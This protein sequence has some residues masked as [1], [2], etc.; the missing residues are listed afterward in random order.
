MHT[1][2]ISSTV[3]EVIPEIIALPMF[4]RGKDILTLRVYQRMNNDPQKL[5]CIDD[6]LDIQKSKRKIR[7]SLDTLISR[8][9]INK[10]NSYP[11]FYYVIPK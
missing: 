2:E 4:E 1:N 10:L 7:M 5:F 8:K 9:M 3:A 11:R 6:F